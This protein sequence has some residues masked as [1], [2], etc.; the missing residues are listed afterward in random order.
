MGKDTDTRAW[1]LALTA[2][3]VRLLHEFA[4]ILPTPEAARDMMFYLEKSIN[5]DIGKIGVSLRQEEA[6]EVLA[7]LR[8]EAR[9]MVSD[10]LAMGR[11]Y[12]KPS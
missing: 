7:Q 5:E 3:N 4:S 12:E 11:F 1:L 8:T 6:P 10:L 9:E 2:M